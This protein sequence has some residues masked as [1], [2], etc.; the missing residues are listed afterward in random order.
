MQTPPS[1]PSLGKGNWPTLSRLAPSWPGPFLAAEPTCCCEAL[2]QG[3]G[4]LASPNE[5][6]AHGVWRPAPTALTAGTVSAGAAAVRWGRI[7]NKKLGGQCQAWPLHRR[8]VT[9]IPAGLTLPRSG[10]PAHRG[11]PTCSRGSQTGGREG[12][13]SLRKGS[14][15][16]MG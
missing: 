7:R 15:R 3:K 13:A 11:V 5:A 1:P 9:P 16:G 10:A 2:G 12:R 6:H 8:P 14:G 4:Q